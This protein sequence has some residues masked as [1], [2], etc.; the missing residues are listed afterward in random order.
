[1]KGSDEVYSVDP[2]KIICLGLNYHEHIEE[3]LSI[4]VQG[5]DKEAPK[6]PILFSKTP[7]ALQGPEQPIMLPRILESYDFED[8]RTDYEAELAI[9]IGREAKD[10]SVEDAS[11]YIFGYT[12]A[13]DVSQRNIQNG[14][15][16]GWFRGKSFDGFAPVGPQIVKGSDIGN[17]LDLHVETRLNG[18]VVQSSSTKLMVFN[19]YEIVSFISRNLTLSPGD[20]ILSG[21]PGGVGPIA[22]GDVV[23]VEIEDIGVLRNPVVDPRRA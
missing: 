8:E 9:I 19:V 14:D 1:V 22:H 12:C 20:I 11:E 5:L 3:S 17:V 15:R 10:V 13:N 2:R 23:E 7:N 4:Q 6:E 16:S 21:T 18:D